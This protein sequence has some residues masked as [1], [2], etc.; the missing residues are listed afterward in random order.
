VKVGTKSKSQ[1]LRGITI[2]ETPEELQIKVRDNFRFKADVR[3][4]FSE[5]PLRTLLLYIVVIGLLSAT[6]ILCAFGILMLIRDIT[7]AITHRQVINFLVPI[8]GFIF[9]IV[10]LSPFLWMPLSDLILLHQP[11]VIQIPKMSDTML[12]ATITRGKY[13]RF[14]CGQPF[15]AVYVRATSDHKKFPFS[16][17]IHANK[18]AVLFNHL[19]HEQ[20]VYIARVIHQ[21]LKLDAVEG[22][23]IEPE[24]ESPLMVEDD[25][26]PVKD[27]GS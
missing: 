1:R 4:S 13:R 22:E 5:K 7:Q 21:Y 6:I 8:A 12:T 2:E 10:L 26:I 19:T 27:K 17:I 23:F 20:A 9:C 14:L 25:A 16:V 11:K 3:K 18:R 24:D 15:K